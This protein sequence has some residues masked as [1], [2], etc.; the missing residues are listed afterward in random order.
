M[1][2]IIYLSEFLGTATLILLG[3]GVNYSV[4]A[5]KMFANQSGKW[6]VIALGWGSWCAFGNYGC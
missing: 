1:E 3:N 5:T 4:S 6:I 2:N